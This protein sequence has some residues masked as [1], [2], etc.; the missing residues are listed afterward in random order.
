MNVENQKKEWF[1]DW[2]NSEYYH[3]LYKNRDYSEAAAF[4][5]NLVATLKPGLED[6]IADLACGKGRHSI[7]LNSLGHKLTGID[8]SPES[9]AH[10]SKFENERLQFFVGDLR[11]LNFPSRFDLALNLFTS[12]G[13]FDSM[14][15]NL[16]CLQSIKTCLKPGGRL[17]IDFLNAE[18]VKQVLVPYHEKTESGIVFRI[19][20]S[21]CDGKVVKNIEF[22]TDKGEFHFQEKVQL[23]S[24]TDF[25]ELLSAA[26]FKLLNEWGD[27]QLGAFNPEKS[28]RYIL[29]AERNA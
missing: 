21:I 3:I 2:F 19:S 18:W 6:E 15:V 9:I 16:Q 1:A 12:F 26:G 4:L 5:D 17:L 14:D 24:Q 8:L 10:A 23:L 25:H 11:G 13:Y 22:E 28:E 7:Y 29:L 27:Y 20:K